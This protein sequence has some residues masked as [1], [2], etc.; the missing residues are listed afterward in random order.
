MAS[1]WKNYGGY[2]NPYE[3]DQQVLP[4]PGPSSYHSY[5]VPHLNFLIS[6]D[7]ETNTID[8]TVENGFVVTSDQGAPDSYVRLIAG[9][10][11]QVTT[12]QE[13]TRTPFWGESFEF[14]YHIGENVFVEVW[15]RNRY[16]MDQKIGVGTLV[17]GF[18]DDFTPQHEYLAL[19]APVKVPPLANGFRRAPNCGPVAMYHPGSNPYGHDKVPK[20]GSW[21]WERGAGAGGGYTSP[22]QQ[23]PTNSTLSDITPVSPIVAVPVSSTDYSGASGGAGYTSPQRYPDYQETTNTYQ[24]YQSYHQY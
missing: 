14:P 22:Q 17:I 2:E 23:R 21:G 12:V 6:K 9:G 5:A 20:W 7:S 4:A 16:G 3:F 18:V 1:S 10:H 11:P 15:T 24:S 13:N 19:T 8:V